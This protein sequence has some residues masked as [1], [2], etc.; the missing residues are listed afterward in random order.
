MGRGRM[1]AIATVIFDYGGVLADVQTPAHGFEAMGHFVHRLI[2][3]SRL[4]PAIISEDIEGAWGAYDGWKR[5][6]N[7]R[8][9]PLEMSQDTFWDLVTYGWQDVERDVILA[10]TARLTQELELQVISRP[11]NPGVAQVLKTLRHG[12]KKLVLASN[13]LSGAAARVQ[14][15]H[16]GLLELFDATLFSD[17]VGYRKP[18]PQLLEEALAAVQ[19][20]AHEAC[21]V[22][23]RLDR[24]ILAGRRA[25]LALCILRQAPSGPGRPVRGVEPDHRIKDLEELL[26]LPELGRLGT[27][28]PDSPLDRSAFN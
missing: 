9:I 17:E 14:L 23:D 28:T 24:D 27:P 3:H 7:R 4:S 21:F 5:L 13:C 18:G 10:N 11:A 16:D 8:R 1:T 26:L 22:G 15:R 20:P 19:T 2:P 25:G 12:G 6:Q